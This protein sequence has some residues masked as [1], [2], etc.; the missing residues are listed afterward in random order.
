MRELLPNSYPFR[1]T[2]AFG[3]NDKTQD[4][5]SNNTVAFSTVLA[6]VNVVNTQNNP[7]NNAVVTYYS[8][9][10]RS[11]G[12]TVN[13]NATKELLPANLQFRAQSGSVLQN[14][15]QDLST[16][17]VIVITLNVGQ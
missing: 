11:F 13:G 4:V 1:M 5:G 10:W 17:P 6:T 9:A 8:G 15:T 7:V 16:N 14:K 2:Y 3:S 12:S